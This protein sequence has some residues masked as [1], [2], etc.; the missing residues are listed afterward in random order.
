M[1]VIDFAKEQLISDIAELEKEEEKEAGQLNDYM[2]KLKLHGVLANY[3]IKR[4]TNTSFTEDLDIAEK[5]SVFLAAKKM[6]GLSPLTLEGYKLELRMFDEAIKKE[7]ENVTSNDIRMY[8]SHF[9]TLKRSTISEK[10]SVLK[11][12]FTCLHTK[13]KL[14]HVTQHL[15]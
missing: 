3:D 5:V 13:K 4:D 2:L 14:L 11:S 12:F 8:L 1:K 9:D 10:P 15:K 6:E 7:V